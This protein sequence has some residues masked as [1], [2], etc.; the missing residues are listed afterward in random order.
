MATTRRVR[1]D[2]RNIQKA[3]AAATR[4]RTIANLPK[5]TRSDLGKQASKAR[6]RF[7]EPS[8]LPDP[9]R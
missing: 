5:S 1:A 3:R 8:W 9:G 2:K 6:Q 7:P 4:K